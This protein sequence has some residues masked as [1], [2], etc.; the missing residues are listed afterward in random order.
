MNRA[1][2]LCR[3]TKVERYG[4]TVQDA[5]GHHRMVDK[6]DLLVDHAYQRDTNERKLMAIARS[7]SWV[8]CG[9][10]VVADREGVLFVVDGQHRVMAARRRSDIAELP[11]LVF[12]T[13]DARQEAEGF[14][15]AQT[16]RKPITAVEK[17]RALVT[18]ED[19]AAMMVQELLMSTGHT[20]GNRAGEAWVKCLGV[21]IKE[22]G[23]DAVSLRRVWPLIST[24]S[25]SAAIHGRLVEG[26]LYIER[27]MLSGAS[28][29]DPEWTKRVKKVGR[30]ALLEAAAKAAAFYA[31]GGA[32]VWAAG[33]VE[34]INRGHRNRLEINQ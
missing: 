34:A 33:M 4:W 21:L 23:A 13:Y 12:R 19:R 18:V 20:A 1:E 22:A 25:G 6:N 16:Q 27:H 14:L 29:A 31:R 15:A 32:K 5:P 10:I 26:I 8:A 2:T 24:V 30:D 28:L 7:W 17:Y 9:S 11:C 3:V